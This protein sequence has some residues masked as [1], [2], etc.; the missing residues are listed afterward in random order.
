MVSNSLVSSKP[1]EIITFS[2]NGLASLAFLSLMRK[3][4]RVT[5]DSSLL[6]SYVQYFGQTPRCS[7]IRSLGTGFSPISKWKISLDYMMRF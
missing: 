6:A 7:S 1:E 5:S 2:E 4:L 3:D